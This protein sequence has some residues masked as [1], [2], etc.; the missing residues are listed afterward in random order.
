M[1]HMIILTY[2]DINLL[3]YI[4]LTW[5]VI[6]LSSSIRSINDL[7]YQNKSKIKYKMLELKVPNLNC[8][9]AASFKAM[10]ILKIEF[11]GLKI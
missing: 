8:R 2:L 3:I 10:L 6:I 11:G 4:R 9:E 7:N 1:T 5:L